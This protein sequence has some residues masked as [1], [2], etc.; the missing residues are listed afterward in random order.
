MQF[1]AE[2]ADD[3]QDVA[4]E[5]D[6]SM[7]PKSEA[8][9]VENSDAPEVPSEPAEPPPEIKVT[10]KDP[11]TVSSDWETILRDRLHE[12]LLFGCLFLFQTLGLMYN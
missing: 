7:E 4:E 10:K 11:S 3:E 12:G 8:H 6:I 9:A 2:A 1:H 5:A